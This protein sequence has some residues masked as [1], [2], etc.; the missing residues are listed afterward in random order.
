MPHASQNKNEV[1]QTTLFHLCIIYL[2]WERLGCQSRKMLYVGRKGL[3]LYAEAIGSIA[4]RIPMN[5]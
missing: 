2:V 5:K 1:K 3:D 4:Q